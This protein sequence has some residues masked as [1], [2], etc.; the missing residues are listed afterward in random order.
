MGGLNGLI[1]K[2]E[3]RCREKGGRGTRGMGTY[4]QMGR[5]ENGPRG[6]RH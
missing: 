5:D 2:R 6:R 3:T 1:E 4:G